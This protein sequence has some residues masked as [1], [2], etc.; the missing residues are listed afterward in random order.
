MYLVHLRV[1]DGSTFA[2]RCREL[3]RDALVPGNLLLLGVLDPV[4]T[5]GGPFSAHAW[6]VGASDVANYMQGD[7]V[8]VPVVPSGDCDCVAS[9]PADR[10]VVDC[11]DRD[12]DTALV[13][14]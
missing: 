12:D 6:S 7:Y 13:A 9:A 10:D 4:P 1:S 2:V 11:D 8:V 5:P 14:R 3:S